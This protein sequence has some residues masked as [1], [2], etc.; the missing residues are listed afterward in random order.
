M[1]DHVINGAEHVGVGEE[2]QLVEG[3]ESN[4]MLW[5]GSRQA[6]RSRSLEVG[7]RPEDELGE[8]GRRY[9]SF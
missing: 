2:T 3:D 5:H 6:S 9:E 4:R 7:R 8:C 1:A